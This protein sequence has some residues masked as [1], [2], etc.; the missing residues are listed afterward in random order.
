MV[1]PALFLLVFC[2]VMATTSYREWQAATNN[3]PRK[4]V[5]CFGGACVFAFVE[6]IWINLFPPK[7]LEHFELPNAPQGV[8]LTAPDGR[9]FI[10]SAPIARVQRYGPEGFE[11]GFMYGRKA[12]EFGMSWSG[13]IL[14]CATGGELL[15][16]SS[17]GIEV[18]PRGPCKD[19]LINSPSP[20]PSHAEVPTIAFNW[21][22]ALAVPL[23]HPV[24]AWLVALVGGLLYYLVDLC[25]RRHERC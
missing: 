25:R 8:R 2:G 16:Y 7:L 9:V 12:F 13:N 19:G 5:I 10:V 17:D 21:F 22:S 1:L 14:I 6:P 3:L 15:T 20:F 4:L 24:A 11:K 23:W 18:Q